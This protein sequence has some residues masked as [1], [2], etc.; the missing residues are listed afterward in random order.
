M[1]V[2]PQ[3]HESSRVCRS[4][5]IERVIQVAKL[6]P[7]LALTLCLTSASPSSDTTLLAPDGQR[8]LGAH[9]ELPTLLSLVRS[10]RDADREFFNSLRALSTEVRILVASTAE[11]YR[12]R[13]YFTLLIATTS[14]DIDA[15]HRAVRTLEVDPLP[16]LA[17]KDPGAKALAGMLLDPRFKARANVL[18]GWAFELRE[19]DHGLDVL[20]AATDG[21]VVLSQAEASNIAAR[22]DLSASLLR[23]MR[24]DLQALSPSASQA[25]EDTMRAEAVKELARVAS[26]PEGEGVRRVA[27]ARML[28]QTRAEAARIESVLFT[29]R[30]AHQA[31]ELL[32]WRT[33]IFQE[34][35]PR[36]ADALLWLPDTAEGRAAPA[37]IASAPRTER[38]RRGAAVARAGLVIDPLD[39]DLAWVAAHGT[40][41][42]WGIP[43]S[44]PFY[45]RFLALRGIRSHDHRTHQDRELNARE[46]EALDAVQRTLIP[47][48]SPQSGF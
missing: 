33:R 42:H 47:G 24:N 2:A 4:A 40:D 45:D 12:Q 18:E 32:E 36:R 11:R 10:T 22:V 26:A 6:V 9:T 48:R 13:G 25:A 41:F 44:R 35:Q 1:A 31:A 17:S 39:E 16:R 43:E 30:L 38:F 21:F 27:V 19:L 7:A 46:R 34:S 8:G 20:R 29:P 23:A 37:E 28:E 15:L 5:G 14:S 3:F